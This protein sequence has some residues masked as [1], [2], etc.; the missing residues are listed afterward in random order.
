MLADQHGLASPWPCASMA[1]VGLA[2]Q[3]LRMLRHCASV[4]TDVAA[5]RL[6]GYGCCGVATGGL[7]PQC[8]RMLLVFSSDSRV[9]DSF[10]RVSIYFRALHD[11]YHTVRIGASFRHLPHRLVSD[12]LAA[13][14]LKCAGGSMKS[15]LV[16][17]RSVADCQ[18]GPCR[19]FRSATRLPTSN[20]FVRQDLLSCLVA[21][22]SWSRLRA[23]PSWSRLLAITALYRYLCFAAGGAIVVPTALRESLLPLLWRL[24][25]PLTPIRHPPHP[26][27]RMQFCSRELLY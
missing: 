27:L 7:V 18:F 9:L 25:P 12:H 21:G 1:T 6:N 20:H 5:L 24:S 15:A 4:V 23:G 26:C 2:P 8:L 16:G 14:Q 11:S 17:R 3:W 13:V 22:P 19:P 10:R